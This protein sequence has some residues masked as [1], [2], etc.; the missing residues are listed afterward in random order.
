MPRQGPAKADTLAQQRVV[1]GRGE[2]PPGFTN[3]DDSVA[4]ATRE[5]MHRVLDELA[6]DTV[7]LR[8]QLEEATEQ[9][10][11]L[12]ALLRDLHLA[13]D[14]PCPLLTACTLRTPAIDVGCASDGGWTA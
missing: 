1:Q 8:D 13:G 6:Q 4:G 12:L 3:N 7:M 11:A 14:L 10:E 5:E 2:T 9:N